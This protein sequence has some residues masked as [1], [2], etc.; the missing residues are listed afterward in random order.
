MAI[1]L[2]G[3]WHKHQKSGGV[4]YAFYRA[5]KYLIWRIA[6]PGFKA[7]DNIKK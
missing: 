5:F 2:W 7:R 3:R 4:I 1:K 6:N